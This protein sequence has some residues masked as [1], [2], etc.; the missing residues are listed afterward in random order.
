MTD[1]DPKLD[2]VIRQAL[3]RTVDQLDGETRSKL[4]QARVKALASLNRPKTV[5]WFSAPVPVLASVLV[6]FMGLSLW[7]SQPEPAI[8]I[9]A[10][11]DLE[12]LAASEPLDLYDDLEFFM[13]L[14][15][16][17]IGSS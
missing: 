13:W 1:H 10:D 11:T 9:A 6:I 17:D 15:E 5:A 8:D 16:Q 7:N 3:D 4:A 12:F 14:S 2:S